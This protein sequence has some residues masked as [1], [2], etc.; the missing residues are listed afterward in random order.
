MPP[1]INEK[2]LY[3]VRLSGR[4]ELFGVKMYPGRIYEVQG[5]YLADI[6]EVVA[7]AEEI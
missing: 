3:R 7:N 1:K 5:R 6:A 4:T 2:A